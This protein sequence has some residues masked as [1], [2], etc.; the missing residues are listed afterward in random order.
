MSNFRG[1][2]F[3]IELLTS[4]IPAAQAFYKN[5]IGWDMQDFGAGPHP[6]TVLSASGV[7]VGGLMQMPDDFRAAGGR[8]CWTGYV[9]TD[10][11]D[12]TAKRVQSVGGSIRRPPEDIPGVG[13]FAVVADPHGAVFM[14]L[15][16]SSPDGPADMPPGTPGHLGWSELHAGEVNSAFA[17]YTGLFGWTK[18]D[19]VDMG[20]M[21][22]YQLFA[23]DGVARGG[24]MTRLPAMAAPCWLHYFNVDSAGATVDRVRAAGG[25][26]LN[27]PHQVPGGGW[28]A[29]CLDPQ[30]AMFAVVAPKP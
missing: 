28:I 5:V 17:F 23:I 29:Q 2:F 4:D 1:R 22:V 26:V 21:G 13:R 3:W 20:P 10:D 30:G 18:A 14:L 12:A 24:M 19:S 25:K 15:K 27:G 11:V 9:G 7:G 8:P 6:Y 16:G